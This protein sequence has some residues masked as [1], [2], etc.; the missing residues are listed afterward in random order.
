MLDRK[1]LK[2][3][4]KNQLRGQWTTVVLINLLFIVIEFIIANLLNFSEVNISITMLIS[5]LNLVTMAFINIS[6]YNLFIKLTRGKKVK[7]NDIFFTGKTFIKTIG[8]MLIQSILVTVLFIILYFILF[9]LLFI[10]SSSIILLFIISVVIMMI[11]F[12]YLYPSIILMCE[13]EDRGIFECISMSFSLM[14]G[15]VW[16]YIVLQLSFI[17]WDLLC[18]LSLG[19]GLLWLIPYQNT[20]NMNFFNEIV[21]YNQV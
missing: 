4:S 15:N 16:R 20:V 8:I 12:A 7:F 3:L 13:D 19:I 18:I 11:L 2:A 9:G 6:T 21:G 1:E 14:H 10:T 17:G 5:I